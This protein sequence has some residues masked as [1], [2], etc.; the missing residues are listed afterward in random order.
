MCERAHSVYFSEGTAQAL[1]EG[2]DQQSPESESVT[3]PEADC[4]PEVLGTTQAGP[5][6]RAS[7]TG[8]LS[9]LLALSLLLWLS[10]SPLWVQMTGKTLRDA[11][12]SPWHGLRR[13]TYPAPW[14]PRY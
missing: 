2:P 10:H 5:M 9:V 4:N 8:P 6:S 12:S 13:L 11:G 7:W 1:N 3:H 14:Q